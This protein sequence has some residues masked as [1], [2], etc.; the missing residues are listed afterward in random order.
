MNS[1]AH[2]DNVMSPR[3]N[4]VGVGVVHANGKLWVAVRF[5][6]G[7][8]ISGSTG[9]A[10]AP[11]PAPALPPLPSTPIRSITNACPSQ[12]TLVTPFLDLAGHAHAKHVACALL[13]DLVAGRSATAFAPHPPLTR[14]PPPTYLPPPPP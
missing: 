9:Q 8:A 7:P 2:R 14:P 12:T 3:F 11:P 5:L 1:P 10:S 13:L 6:D 4:R